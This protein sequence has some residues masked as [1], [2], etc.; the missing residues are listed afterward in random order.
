MPTSLEFLIRAR[1]DASRVLKDVG[2]DARDAMDMAREKTKE[3]DEELAEV[4]TTLRNA[5]AAMSLMATGPLLLLANSSTDAAVSLGESVNAINVTFEEGADVI[6]RFAETSASEIGL[7][8]RAVNE[9]LTPVGAMLRNVGFDATTAAESSVDLATRA[10][11][12]ASVFNVDVNEALAAISAG[13]RGE[14]EPLRRFGVGLDDAAVRAKAVSLGLAESADAVEDNALAQGRMAL[15]LEQ[16]NRLAGDF[17]NTSDGVANSERINAAEAEDLAATYG[18]DL[19]PAKK[20][21]T[22]AIR[23]VLDLFA[24]L[25]PEMRTTV[26]AVG[27]VVAAVG[28]L[29]L[30]ASQLIGAI[31]GIGAALLFLQANPIVLVIAAVAALGAGLVWLWN[32]SK[33]FRAIV[34]GVFERVA[35][36]VGPIL[37]AIGRGIDVLGRAFTGLG[38]IVGKVWD[39]IVSGVKGAINFVIG[40]ING[41]IRMINSVQIH[42]PRI[43][44]DT[45]AGFIGVG[46]F[47]WGGLRLPQIPSLA[48]GAWELLDDTLAFLHR[49]EMVVPA[50]PAEAIRQAA[51]GGDRFPGNGPLV[52]IGAVYG[53]LPGELERQTERAVRRAVTAWGFGR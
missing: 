33:E 38:T 27:A 2:E 44:L 30:V 31:R 43:G 8:A 24:S 23:S 14:A 35:A 4:Q 5:G 19:I 20:A 29:L 34:T 12:M 50:A 52:T 46:P 18:E 36:V 22:D 41:F 16:T 15:I 37:A 1:N 25:S 7:S 48:I 40:L 45:P 21:L 32:N 42:I 47:D 49:G 9:A 51:E 26:I 6:H 13:L 28:P 3:W 53:V 17:K 11:D 39:G 10:A